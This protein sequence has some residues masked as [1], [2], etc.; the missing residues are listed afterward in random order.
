MR[1]RRYKVLGRTFFT[2][3]GAVRYFDTLYGD[4]E[5][6]EWKYGEWHWVLQKV[7]GELTRRLLG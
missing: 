2:W 5:M 1:V 3:K 7:N 6:F 4:K